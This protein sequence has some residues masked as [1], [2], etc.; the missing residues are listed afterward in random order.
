MEVTLLDEGLREST[1]RLLHGASITTL[2]GVC[3]GGSIDGLAAQSSA[4]TTEVGTAV[5]CYEHASA[6]AAQLLLAA[7]VHFNATE[8]S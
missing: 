5:R 6:F 4:Q 1:T 3:D 7:L 2:D 8:K